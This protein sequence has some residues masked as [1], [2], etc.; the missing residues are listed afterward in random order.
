MYSPVHHDPGLVRLLT[1]RDVID[2]IHLR[3]Y[4]ERETSVTVDPAFRFTADRWAT[5]ISRA[6][7]SAQFRARIITVGTTFI[8]IYVYL[9]PVDQNLDL[10]F[11]RLYP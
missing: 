4:I 1:K 3:T 7:V 9:P 2:P 11:G 6:P 5:F 8:R 10:S